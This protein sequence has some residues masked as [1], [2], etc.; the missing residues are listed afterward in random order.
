[1]FSEQS[2]N[3]QFGTKQTTKP[4]MVRPADHAPEA[5]R[6]RFSAVLFREKA[7]YADD[8]GAEIAWLVCRKFE[9]L[10]SVLYFDIILCW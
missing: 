10:C 7:P 8:D 5:D 3:Y 1:M 6:T 4:R 2:V 9:K